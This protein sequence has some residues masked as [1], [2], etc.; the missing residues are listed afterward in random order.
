MISPFECQKLLNPIISD[1]LHAASLFYYENSTK[2]CKITLFNNNNNTSIYNAPVPRIL[3]SMNN[4]INN[5]ILHI[6][7]KN[8]RSLCSLV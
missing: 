1:F 5:E 4:E 3:K 8:S 6:M 7:S 2:Y